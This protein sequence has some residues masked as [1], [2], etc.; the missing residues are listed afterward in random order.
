MEELLKFK[1]IYGDKHVINGFGV[2]INPSIEI[3]TEVA[4]LRVWFQVERKKINEK[5]KDV[6]GLAPLEVLKNKAILKKQEK[7]NSEMNEFSLIWDKKLHALGKVAVNEWS[8]GA[9]D[10]QCYLIQHPVHKFQ[11]S[12]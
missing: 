6:V 4:K 1:N 2:N 9:Y 10:R 8:E 12:N 3:Y 7:Y 5:Y 11:K